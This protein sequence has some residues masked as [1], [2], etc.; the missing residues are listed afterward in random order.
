M[1]AVR[2]VRIQDIFGHIAVGSCTPRLFAVPPSTPMSAGAGPRARAKS[3][4]DRL[5]G[6]RDAQLRRRFSV[7]L[8]AQSRF[9]PR[10]WKPSLVDYLYTSFTNA[11]AFSPTDT[12][13]LTQTAKW[14]M[15]VQALTALLTVGL[16]VARAVNI[17]S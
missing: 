10:G 11:T 14:L 2:G 15:S 6:M 12:M 17:L 5:E 13:P 4:R 8:I 9:A 7:G 16:V 3:L 1:I